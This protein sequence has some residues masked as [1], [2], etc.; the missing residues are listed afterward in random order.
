MI[1]IFSKSFF[2]NWLNDLGVYVSLMQD[3]MFNTGYM[4]R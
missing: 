2:D 3:L 1:N 4:R